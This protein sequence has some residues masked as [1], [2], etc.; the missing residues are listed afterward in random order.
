[1]ILLQV[2]LSDTKLQLEQRLFTTLH[3]SLNSKNN[4]LILF[5]DIYLNII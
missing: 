1:L 2:I 3:H 4:H 5:H